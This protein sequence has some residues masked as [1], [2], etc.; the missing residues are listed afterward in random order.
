M[1]QEVVLETK[2]HIKVHRYSRIFI[3]FSKTIP[4][5]GAY[6]TA[7]TLIASC[8]CMIIHSDTTNQDYRA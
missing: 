5:F 1:N 6:Q 2:M 7:T 4:I 8:V 3:S